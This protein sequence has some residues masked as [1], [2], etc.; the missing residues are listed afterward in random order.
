MTFSTQTL[1]Q[2]VVNGIAFQNYDGSTDNFATDPLAAA[3]FYGGQGSVQTAIITVTNFTG[4]ITLQASLNKDS[5]TAS[6]FDVEIY[7]T[8]ARPVASETTSYTMTGNFVWIRA[9]VSQFST[10]IIN[11]ITVSY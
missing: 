1:L 9:A 11:S 4:I 5:K 7:D 10:G 6:W 2:T 3:N 8:T